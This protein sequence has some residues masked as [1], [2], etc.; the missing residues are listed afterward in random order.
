MSCSLF[1]VGKEQGPFCR[2]T[3]ELFGLAIILFT[4]MPVV[5][6]EHLAM[7]CKLHEKQES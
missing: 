7:F 2:G 1:A 3:G 4:M 5:R 6:V